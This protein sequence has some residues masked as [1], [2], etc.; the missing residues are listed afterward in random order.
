M[1]SEWRFELLSWIYFFHTHTPQKINMQ[2]KNHPIEKENHLPNLHFWVPYASSCCRVYAPCFWFLA[3]VSLVNPV[4][5]LES[6][7]DPYHS[8]S[9]FGF[10]FFCLIPRFPKKSG[11]REPFEI[12]PWKKITAGSSKQPTKNIQKWKSGKSNLIHPPWKM[13]Y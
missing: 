2:P 1:C 7:Q 12:H 9:Q 8:I 4:V 3:K 6:D 10:C 11:P 5:I 13:T